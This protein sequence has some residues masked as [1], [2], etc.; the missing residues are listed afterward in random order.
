MWVMADVMLE[1][2]NPS[3]GSSIMNSMQSM[4]TMYAVNDANIDNK[5]SQQL[6]VHIHMHTGKH[7][8]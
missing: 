7:D 6:T 2:W 5:C 4:M 8:G 3:S 1:Y